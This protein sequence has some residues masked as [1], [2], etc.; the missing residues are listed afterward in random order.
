MTWCSRRIS[1]MLWFV[2]LVTCL[3]A[4]GGKVGPV[5]RALHKIDD[6]FLFFFLLTVSGSWVGRRVGDGKK[7][8]Y[9]TLPSVPVPP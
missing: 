2:C 8:S 1:G 4:A 5:S 9:S 3:R 6:S 7:V